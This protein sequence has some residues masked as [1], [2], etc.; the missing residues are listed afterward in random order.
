MNSVPLHPSIVHI[1]IALAVLMP[2]VAGGL[3]L[4]WWRGWFP[5]RV[6]IVAVL[7]Q[8]TLVGTSFAAL[9]TGEGDEERVEKVLASEAGLE[10]H[11]EAAEGFFLATIAVLVLMGA[12]ALIP[13]ES[14]GRGAL[15]V[16]V[17]GTLVVAG[18]GYRV[19]HAGGELVY[20]DGAARA[21]ETR[22]GN[23]MAPATAM[24]VDH[25]GDDDDDDDSDDDD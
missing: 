22:S 4:A 1:P 18:L 17:V 2:L 25:D 23:G 20:L 13:K 19:G 24:D 15:A 16:A 7:M 11:E 12:G 8:A 6:L 5:R 9:E 14:V 3:L 21:Y 10:A